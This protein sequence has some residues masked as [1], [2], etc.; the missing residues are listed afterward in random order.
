[1]FGHVSDKSQNEKTTFN[2]QSPYAVSKVFGHFMTIN[3]RK[4]YN[5]F[6][7]SGILFNHE[8]PLR[9]EE[10]VTRKI[11]LGLVKIIKNEFY[12]GNFFKKQKHFFFIAN[13]L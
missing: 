2:P 9:S 13:K 12:K 6:A 4:S 3:Y 8:S 1:M 11:T 10:F 5:L 7:T